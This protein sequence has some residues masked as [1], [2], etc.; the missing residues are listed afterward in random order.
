M[1]ETDGCSGL[2][3]PLLPG[4]IRLLRLQSSTDAI[5]EC[6]LETVELSSVPDYFALSYVWG[7][8][9]TDA[10]L[11]L[12][13]MTI[14]VRPNLLAGLRAIQ[15]FERTLGGALQMRVWIDA[16]CIDQSSLL[17]KSEQ[18][19]MMGRIYSGAYC[20][21]IWMSDMP[22]SA[23]VVYEVLYWCQVK[24]EIGVLAKDDS[25]DTDFLEHETERLALKSVTG[26]RRRINQ[27][28]SHSRRS[29]IGKKSADEM[30]WAK[31]IQESSQ[32]LQH[33]F[34][35]TNVEIEAFHYLIVAIHDLETEPS[36]MISDERVMDL[37][38]KTWA[39][40]ALFDPDHVFWTAL[41]TFMDHDWFWRVWTYQEVM[42][43]RTAAIL[44]PDGRIFDWHVVRACRG[45]MLLP[46]NFGVL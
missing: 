32:R 13:G 19:P 30:F 40:R 12:H 29:L 8:A 10:Q 5:L 35:V 4:H 22:Q 14:P 44:C 24:H 23:D 39:T 34:G 26:K 20:V 2:Y 11:L 16:L 17:E 36:G 28:K 33:Q 45:A 43:A 1:H 7:D 41:F 21:L 3:E 9:A 38:N 46:I 15:K 27:L 31:K 37:Y 6:R 18:I 42:L 25:E